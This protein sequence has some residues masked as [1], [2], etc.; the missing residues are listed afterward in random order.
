[1]SAFGDVVQDVRA[2]LGSP[3]GQSNKFITYFNLLDAFR[4]P[5]CPVCALLEQGERK[6]LDSLLYEQ[7][8]DPTT[9]EHLVASHGLCNWHAWMS[10]S[11]ANSASGVALIYRHCLNET[12]TRVTETLRAV[13]P[14][15]RWGRIKAWL[16]DGR[17][18][19]LP[20][21]DWRSKNQRC[22]LCTSSRRTERR[23][24]QTILEFLGEAPFAE[25]FGRSTGLCLPHLCLTATLGRDHP[26]LRSL[27]TTQETRWRNL[28]GE[29]DEFIRKFDYRYANEARGEEGSSWSR[30]VEALVGR[31]AV[32]GPER[33]GDPASFEGDHAPEIAAGD[34]RGDRPPSP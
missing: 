24:L 17:E 15:S 18:E 14:R 11:V 7:V 29:L 13:R 33:W 28:V 20:L 2:I 4:V 10:P 1:M 25:A 6:A 3:R 22:Y 34:G 31:R 8:N 5:G 19:P 27:L 23:Y 9:R 16:F 26:N 30:A 12:L 21:L 32:F